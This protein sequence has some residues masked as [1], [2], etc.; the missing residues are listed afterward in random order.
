MTS[1]Q[2]FFVAS[3]LCF[4]V[5]VMGTAGY[6]VLE[7]YSLTDGL[8]MTVI[9][10]STVGF[11]E[12]RPLGPGGRA[13][14]SFLIAAGFAVIGF[15]GHALGESFLE[16]IASASSERKRM[17]KLISELK[18]HYIICGCGRVGIAAAEHFEKS[19]KDFVVIDSAASRKD[20]LEARELLHLVGDATSEEL[21]NEARIKTARGLI[22]V[23]P[24][25]PDNLFITLTARELNP[26]LH[27]IARAEE[28]SSERKL[29][30]AG[31]D[32][33]ISPFATAGRQIASNMLVATG[34]SREIE[35]VCTFT[36]PDVT[37][38]WVLVQEGSSMAGHTVETVAAEMSRKIVGLRR[39]ETDSLDPH[40]DFRIEEGDMLL[41]I[42]ER[43]AEEE[44]PQ[45]PSRMRRVAVVDDNPVILGLYTRLVQRAGFVPM[46]AS[47]GSEA[48]GLIR[49]EKPDA[50]VIGAKLP[51][52]NGLEVCRR[53]RADDSLRDVRLV[54]FTDQ[55]TPESRKRAKEIGVNA[56]VV[57]TADAAKLIETLLNLFQP[58]QTG[59][60]PS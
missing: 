30:R 38:Q 34:D 41:V 15:L 36:L 9:T 44:K 29:L 23:L 56:Y 25:D 28:A 26:T 40:P 8:Y 7:G 31:A 58:S 4:S 57:K 51:I 17:K 16:R 13:F 14:T 39:K 59:E 18:G 50:V 52:I 32:N 49:K 2:R 12:V 19:G 53:V 47:D 6:M 27:I 46:G 35:N 24:S 11:G 42:E 55:D 22:A 10:I 5:L 3:L 60:N 21:L 54:L 33:V 37:S 45:G 20:L 48:L 1:R 43:Q